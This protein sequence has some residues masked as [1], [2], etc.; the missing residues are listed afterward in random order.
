MR[1]DDA[2]QQRFTEYFAARRDAVRRTAYFMC[3]DWHWA[4]DL[5]QTAFIRLADGW[6]RIRDA[7]AVDAYLRTCLV[8]AFLSET[9]RVWRRRERSVAEPPD[10]ASDDDSE[11]VAR[12]LLFAQA[13]RE[14]PPRQRVTLVCRFY[15][16]LDVTETAAALGCSEGTVKSQTARGLA[17]LRRAL[18][19]AV[20][21]PAELVSVRG[22]SI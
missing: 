7:R 6:H 11:T 2:E 19:D 20:V 15:Q 18:G 9:R 5:T 10:V 3:G 1:D 13:L 17:A 14:V 4:D 12:R 22:G 16:G 8:R 21:P